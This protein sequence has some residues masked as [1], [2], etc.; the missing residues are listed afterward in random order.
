MT[1]STVQVAEAAQVSI[2]QL[3]WWDERRIVQPRQSGHQRLYDDVKFF[4]ALLVG[5]MRAKKI[6]LQRIRVAIAALPIEKLMAEEDAC[7][8]MRRKGM[9]IC[10]EEQAVR[11]MDSEDGPVWVI[12][13]APLLSTLRRASGGKYPNSCSLPVHHHS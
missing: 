12:R 1:F 2:R 7:V 11:A 6:S 8:L 13:V 10:T 5:R 9:R 3:Q 4:K